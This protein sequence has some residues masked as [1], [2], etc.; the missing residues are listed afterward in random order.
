MQA[1]LQD[2]A[3]FIALVVAV[4]VGLILSRIPVKQLPSWAKSKDGKGVMA[5]VVLA[6]LVIVIFAVIM[7]FLP[8][9]AHAQ[10]RVPGVPGTWLNDGSVFAG[11]DHT[12]KQSSQC[13]AG[14]YDDRSTSNMGLRVNVW[15]S[16]N[17]RLRLNGK[18]SHKSCALNRDR[19]SYDALGIELEWCVWGCY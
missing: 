12:F 3:L 7:F 4:V 9:P 5:G 10:L 18:Y 15:Q 8:S 19:N 16:E 1:F 11:I 17:T 14:G 6:P 13:H 2:A